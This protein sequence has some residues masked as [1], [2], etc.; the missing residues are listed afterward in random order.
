MVKIGVVN[1][2]GA[3]MTMVEVMW[4]YGYRVWWW[5]GRGVKKYGFKSGE[6]K[7]KK[8]KPQWR[9]VVD[10]KERREVENQKKIK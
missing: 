4:W 7:K 3:M 6:I 9:K 10:C 1:G 8:S 2:G 5:S